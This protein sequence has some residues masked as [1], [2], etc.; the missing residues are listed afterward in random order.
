[1]CRP[2]PDAVAVTAAFGGA[3]Q[4][5]TEPRE[6]VRTYEIAETRV[7]CN[8]VG[9]LSVCCSARTPP[10]TAWQVLHAVIEGFT[11]E[12]GHRYVVRVTEREV[13]NPAPD[14]P[15]ILYRLVEVAAKTRVAP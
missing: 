3:C 11:Y 5:S 14:G 2:A 7:P 10:D 13:R 9:G 1:V 8:G 15:G 12:P 6:R 4:G